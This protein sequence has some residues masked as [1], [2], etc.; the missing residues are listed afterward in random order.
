MDIMHMSGISSSRSVGVPALVIGFLAAYLSGY[1]ACSWMIAL[2][3]RG[4]L[5]WF[6]IYCAIIGIIAIIFA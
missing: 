2:V 3:K 6:A 4:K 1:L 5:V